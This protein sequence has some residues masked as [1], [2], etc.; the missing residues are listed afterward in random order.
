MK[1]WKE[2]KRIAEVQLS[3]SFFDS[4]KL[5]GSPKDQT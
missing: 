3:D 1:E 2:G 4:V 5:Q